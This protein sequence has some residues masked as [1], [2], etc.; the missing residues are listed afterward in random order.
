MLSTPSSPFSEAYQAQIASGAIEADAAQA[1]VA[2]AY[3][4]LDLRLAT[5]SCSAACSAAVT[6]TMCRAG[7]TFMARS[8]AARPC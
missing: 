1:E 2:E 7:S 8:A 5:Y 4:A 3:A 6:G